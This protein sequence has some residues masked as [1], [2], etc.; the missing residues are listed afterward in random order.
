LYAYP[1]GLMSR[2]CWC[3]LLAAGVSAVALA[4]DWPQF[5]GPLRNGTSPAGVSEA[6]LRNPR[7]LWRKDVG[8]GFS[9]PVVAGDKLILFHRVANDEVV[10]CLN[11]TTGDRIWR[12]A[13]ATGYR[14][15]FGFDPGPRGTPAIADG[16][17]Y[18]F[19]AEGVLHALDLATGKKIWRVDTHAK[20]GVRKG[21]F[22]AAASPLV[23]GGAVYVNVG[24]PNGAGLVAF[25]A[26]TGNVRWTATNDDAG[27]SSPIAATVEGVKS[28]L[29]L[30]RAGLV[31]ADPATGKVRFQFPW[32][33]RNN[34][35]VNAAVPIVT[36]NLIFL[37][38]SYGTGA[39][40]LKAASNQLTQVWASDESLSNHYASSVYKDGY[41]Y[42][43]HGR[44]EYGQSLRCIELNT[45]KVQWDMDGYGAGTVTLLGDMLFVVRESGEA[46]LARANPKAFAP[47]SK[48]QLL[49]GVLRSYPAIA[50]GKIFVRNEKQL[51]AYAASE[52]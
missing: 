36:G 42:G 29:C 43:F 30:T 41:V 47:L 15:D 26:A 1:E 49:P 8:E 35:S 51:A 40:L 12:F 50:G 22:G 23:D 2:F 33:S 16:K 27:Y 14:D 17:V 46:V 20:F 48:A 34:A 39:V 5:L 11:A 32:R 45:G 24:G 31:A 25:D 4:A 44:Q 37:S 3:S 38:A 28:I 13:Y 10:E 9:A 21:Y 18:S 52:K 6:T 7:P 19:G